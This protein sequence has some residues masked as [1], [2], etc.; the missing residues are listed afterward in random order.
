MVIW[1][2]HHQAILYFAPGH[3][4]QA[5]N[6]EP[7]CKDTIDEVLPHQIVRDPRELMVIL[8]ELGP[9]EDPPLGPLSGEFLQVVSVV[10]VDPVIP[11]VE[12]TNFLLNLHHVQSSSTSWFRVCSQRT[13]V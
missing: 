2:G 4:P 11:G 1:L 5:R 13:A 10:K 8:P 9:G 3:V 12:L 6:I 7:F